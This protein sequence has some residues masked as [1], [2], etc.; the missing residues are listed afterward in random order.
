M[1]HYRIKMI[2]TTSQRNNALM[3]VLNGDADLNNIDLFKD[4]NHSTGFIL[5]RKMVLLIMNSLM[6]V[7]IY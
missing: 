2:Y 7:K 4:L 5:K 3:S 1:V 6:Q